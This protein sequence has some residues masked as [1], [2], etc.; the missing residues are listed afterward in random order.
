MRRWLDYQVE[1]ERNRNNVV[2]GAASSVGECGCGVV[3]GPYEFD[4]DWTSLACV[5]LSFQSRA[6]HSGPQ[7]WPAATCAS[8]IIINHQSALLVP[9]QQAT[10]SPP[11]PPCTSVSRTHCTY[12][13][14]YSHHSATTGHSRIHNTSADDLLHARRPPARFRDR[15]RSC[16]ANSSPPPSL[17]FSCSFFFLPKNPLV[18]RYVWCWQTGTLSTITSFFGRSMS[19]KLTVTLVDI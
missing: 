17:P 5:A 12:S 1:G 6:E 2:A 18:V 16:V 9:L 15:A 11:T 13:I 10:L 8:I 19:T 14:I 7:A 4:Q 3:H